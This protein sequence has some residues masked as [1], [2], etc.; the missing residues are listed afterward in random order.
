[1]AGTR[2]ASGDQMPVDRA[3]AGS[4]LSCVAGS[5]GQGSRGVSA[6]GSAVQPRPVSPPLRPGLRGHPT[7]ASAGLPPGRG[8]PCARRP[9]LS[10]SN[11]QDGTRE[12]SSSRWSTCVTLEREDIPPR[13]PS[14]AKASDT[15]RAGACL[16]KN[17]DKQATRPTP[18]GPRPSSG[19]HE[20]PRRAEGNQGSIRKEENGGGGRHWTASRGPLAGPLPD[21]SPHGTALPETGSPLVPW[22]LWKRS[23]FLLKDQFRLSR[24]LAGESLFN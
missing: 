13:G 10:G 14:T 23:A 20:A 21:A 1:M 5:P 15:S 24:S 12:S 4:S 18:Q 16:S 2:A 11:V 17:S 3:S 7:P 9:R 8:A 19:K 22:T 6:R